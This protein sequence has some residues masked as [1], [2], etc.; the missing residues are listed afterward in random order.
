VESIFSSLEAAILGR[1]GGKA[2]NDPL[3]PILSEGQEAEPYQDV[4]PYDV[5]N[6]NRQSLGHLLAA[7]HA[8]RSNDYSPPEC[9]LRPWESVLIPE[10]HSLSEPYDLSVISMPPEMYDVN[11]DSLNGGEGQIGTIKFFAEDVSGLTLCLLRLTERSSHPLIH[12]LAGHY[13]VLFTIPYISLKSTERNVLDYYLQFVNTYRKTPS[14][15]WRQLPTPKT[16]LLRPR[17]SPSNH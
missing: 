17:P 2:L 5:D 11:E 3:C 14:S 7:L 12:P 16:S 6:A 8:F 4:S 1:R 13:A 9:L 15:R 10:G